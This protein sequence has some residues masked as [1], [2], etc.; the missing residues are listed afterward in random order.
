M[1]TRKFRAT[2]LA[3]TVAALVAVP[4]AAAQTAPEEGSETPR[5]TVRV[6]NNNWDDVTVYAVRD[7]Y[8]HRL[9]KLTS[10][11]SRVFTLPPTFL[12]WTGE[13]R[14]IADPIAPVGF[15]RASSGRN[16]TAV[17]GPGDPFAPVEI[18]S[19]L[20][21]RNSTAIRGRR[22]AYVSEPLL[23]NAGDVVEW[24]LLSNIKLSNIFIYRFRGE[25]L[26][27]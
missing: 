22:V 3:L 25:E 13:I 18:S 20:S 17:P 24:R 8:R 14:L 16:S 23:V 11:T 4:A 6:I 26:Q 12:I 5:T 9:G 1:N 7:G 21:G 10:F 2:F 15:S 27:R 19:G